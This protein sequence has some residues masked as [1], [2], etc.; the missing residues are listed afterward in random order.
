MADR[1]RPDG[2]RHLELSYFDPDEL[3]GVVNGGHLRHTLTGGPNFRADLTHVRLDDFALDRGA[4][5]VPVLVNGSFK[6]DA[7]C[8]GTSTAAERPIV[9]NGA[10]VL[11]MSLQIYC[12][13][14]E[15]EYVAGPNA[16]WYALTVDRAELQRCARALVGGDLPI[17]RRGLMNLRPA[18]PAI[19][20]AR[21]AIDRMLS[22]A[23]G[24][25]NEP[26]RIARRRD[27]LIEA[28]VRAI[29][30]AG[31][32]PGGGPPPGLS[33]RRVAERVREWLETRFGD[34]YSSRAVC[35][36]AGC[37]E[38]YVEIAFRERYQLSPRR[39]HLLRR[40][41]QVRR[42]LLNGKAAEDGVTGVATQA[43]F[44]ELGRFAVLYRE[45]FGERPSETARRKR[46][47]ASLRS[48]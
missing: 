5:S 46:S 29:A 23:G 17:D 7:I 18:P 42:D 31:E 26:Q 6:P 1:P 33:R 41:N 21:R 19:A 4:Y 39:W 9:V 44:Y 30:S 14:C 8:V 11:P 10:L 48:D 38:R 24:G 22:V 3:L 20:A 32:S 47:G 28:Y 40:L 37:S 36:V 15:L 45:L 34:P 35:E 12:E 25:R 27:R 43:G 16:V 13:G 2:F